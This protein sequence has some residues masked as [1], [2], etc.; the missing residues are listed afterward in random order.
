MTNPTNF[1]GWQMPEPTDLVTDLPADFEV[2]GQ[3]VDT[4]FQDLLGG[5]TGQVLSKTSGTDLDFTWIDNDQGD[6]T[7]VTAGTGISGGGTSGTVTVTNSMATAIT[8][9]GDLIYGTGSGTFTRLGIGSTNQVLSVTA[10]VPAWATPSG[11]P[12]GFVMM[13][14]ANAA[15]AGFLKANG[16]AVSRTTYADLFAVTGTTFGVGDGSTTFNVPDLRGYFPR[17]W[18]DDGSIDSGR[19]FGSTQAATSVGTPDAGNDAPQGGFQNSDGTDGSNTTRSPS[20]MEFTSNTYK[21]V[22]PVNLAL[23]ACIKF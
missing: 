13:Y 10:G 18:A 9:N 23:L 15:P 4:D 16:A 14:A 22:R 17:G 2:F 11:V 7:G 1:F 21:K 5:T 6:I 3:A 20:S 8:T 12:A 19:S